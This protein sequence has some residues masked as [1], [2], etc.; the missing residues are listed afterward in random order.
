MEPELRHSL[1]TDQNL[2]KKWAKMIVRLYNEII[3]PYW[4]MKV[5]QI[6]LNPSLCNLVKEQ[7]FSAIEL[8]KL[9]KEWAESDKKTYT[10]LNMKKSHF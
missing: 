4:S 2:L 3:V 6:K 8:N 7:N 10:D 1:A 9:K 5:K